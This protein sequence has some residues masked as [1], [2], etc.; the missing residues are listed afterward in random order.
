MDFAQFLKALAGLVEI[1]IKKI[2]TS[3][4]RS[5]IVR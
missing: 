3:R 5:N 2:Q 1:S 4:A